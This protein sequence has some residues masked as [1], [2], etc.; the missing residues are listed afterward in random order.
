MQP[1]TN[2]NPLLKLIQRVIGRCWLRVR[3]RSMS[4]K[5]RSWK[6]IIQNTQHVQGINTWARGSYL[7][8]RRRFAEVLMDVFLQWFWFSW[9]K[10]GMIFSICTD[11]TK[12]RMLVGHG[13][14]WW[15]VREKSPSHIVLRQQTEN[16]PE[17]WRLCFLMLLEFIFAGL[18]LVDFHVQG[19]WYGFVELE[20]WQQTE[21]LSN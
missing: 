2:D 15:H 9:G 17:V 4:S 6:Q 11:W 10:V 19:Q 14:P 13:D 16:R 18:Y 1:F 12:M 3:D 20:R 21:G 8:I 5:P 7:F